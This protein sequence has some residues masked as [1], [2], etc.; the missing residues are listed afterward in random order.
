MFFGIVGGIYYVKSNF[1][2][3][4]FLLNGLGIA[5]TSAH[6]S[7]DRINAL[8]TCIEIWKRSPLIGYSF[9]GVD[10]LIK[11][12]LGEVYISGDNGSGN[13]IGELLVSSGII[14][15]VPLILYFKNILSKKKYFNL[16]NE[17][18]NYYSALILSFAFE[19]IILC[20]NQ[21]FLRVYVWM[22]I[23]IINCAVI[24]FENSKEK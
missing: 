9:G 17:Q 11:L 8:K 6:S 7:N 5:G 2:N 19:F 4:K 21:N 14:G 22:H 23:A 12:E 16:T 15:L 24:S 20:M 13:T 18:N 3:V 10:P 1:E